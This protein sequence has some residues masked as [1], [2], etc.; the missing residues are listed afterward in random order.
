MTTDN[1]MGVLFEHSVIGRTL[2]LALALGACAP[3]PE[4]SPSERAAGAAAV[5]AWQESG[6]PSASDR[7]DVRGFRI[8]TPGAQDYLRRCFSA[9][10]KSWGCLNW[11]DSGRM[12][13]AS[14]VPVVV[15][16]PHFYADRSAD[17][18]AII[19]HELM[20]ALVTCAGVGPSGWDSGDREHTD[21][22]VWSAAG[23][24][25]SVQARATAL[26]AD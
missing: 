2:A 9:P 7:C 1:R 10:E 4:L 19:Q 20:H 22:R 15:A 18:S 17:L 12:F 11:T 24:E 3:K 5:Q 21:A 16:S 13:G 26:L 23:G 14:R 25:T 8:A 6:L